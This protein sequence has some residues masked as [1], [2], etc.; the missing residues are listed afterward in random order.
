MQ[1]SKGKCQ[2]LH[3]GRNK[4]GHQHMLGADQLGS[5]L[6][7]NDLGVLVD[8]KVTTSQQ[9][10]LAAKVANGFLGR[11]RKNIASRLREV[12]RPLTQHRCGHTWSA[13]SSSGLLS[14]RYRA[15]KMIKGLEHLTDEAERAGT[16]QPGKD[17]A[18]GNLSHV[19]KY[20]M[21]GNRRR[22]SQ[23][24]LSGAQVVK[25]WNTLLR[26]VVE[27]PSEEVLK[28]QLGRMCNFAKAQGIS[29][30]YGT[31]KGETE[32]D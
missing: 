16:V 22:G 1:F 24:L 31:A 12:I 15:M 9:C 29:K 5:S 21:G 27:S 26:E 6:A 28:A 3:L 17:E 14:T 2:I 8:N 7:E 4:P 23:D 25:H 30:S 20:V 11:I 18:Q 19:Y 10:T 13:V 32:E